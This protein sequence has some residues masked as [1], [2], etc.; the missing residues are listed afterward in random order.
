MV[1]WFLLL[2][3]KIK[4]QNSKR[5]KQICSFCLNLLPRSRINLSHFGKMKWLPASERVEHCIANT[6]LSTRMELQPDMFMR[7]ISPHS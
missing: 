2:K 1:S 5:S 6:I 3:K 4:K 7:Y